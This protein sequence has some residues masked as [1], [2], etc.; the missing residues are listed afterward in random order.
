M[1]NG[2]GTCPEPAEIGAFPT[3]GV[4]S[5]STPLIISTMAAPLQPFLPPENQGTEVAKEEAGAE[6]V[7]I[8]PCPPWLL[9]LA[10]LVAFM[11]FRR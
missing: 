1:A 10:I 7:G 2:N 4:P 9:I 3:L 5:L 8:K 11:L 6:S